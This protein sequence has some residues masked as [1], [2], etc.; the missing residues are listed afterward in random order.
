MTL[1]NRCWVTA[2]ERRQSGSSNSLAGGEIRLA[3]S[4][5]ARRGFVNTPRTVV[6]VTDNERFKADP[7][8]RALNSATKLMAVRY[9]KRRERQAA[10]KRMT[11]EARRLAINL[12]FSPG[13]FPERVP[14]PPS[15]LTVPSER[16]IATGK[17]SR[18][19]P[20]IPS[21]WK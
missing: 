3:K 6:V 8:G 2:C 18:D 13:H 9:Q 11:N 16:G 14:E 12:S 19:T 4:A 5:R 21:R 10:E 15:W 20:P 7:S 17:R 1:P